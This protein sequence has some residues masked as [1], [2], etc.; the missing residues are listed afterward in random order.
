[1]LAINSYEIRFMV[2][3]T[4]RL[5]RVEAKRKDAN[6][7][8]SK[9]GTYYIAAAALKRTKVF[10]EQANLPNS[11]KRIHSLTYQLLCHRMAMRSRRRKSKPLVY[12]P[13]D[14]I[15]RRNKC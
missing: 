2:A 4:L 5:A 7:Q 15:K 6:S 1:M 10:G 9:V 12:L 14:S 3:Q 11:I 13:K 8:Y